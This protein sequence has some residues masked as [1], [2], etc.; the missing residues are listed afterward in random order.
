MKAI[1]QSEREMQHYLVHSA[2]SAGNIKQTT[3]RVDWEGR[4]REES[5]PS[6]QTNITKL[7]MS[8]E[9]KEALNRFE[10]QSSSLYNKEV[11]VKQLNESESQA[12]GNSLVLHYDP[13]ARPVTDAAANSFVT[14]GGNDS[15]L[16]ATPNVLNTHENAISNYVDRNSC[17]AAEEDV[18]LYHPDSGQTASLRLPSEVTNTGL[19][20]L[21]GVSTK[22]TRERAHRREAAGRLRDKEL[23]YLRQF[24]SLKEADLD[25]GFNHDA[26]FQYR[27]ELARFD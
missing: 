4:Q 8:I 16:I 24:P 23:A 10:P 7:P 2:S 14:R 27:K 9:H 20:S 13:S 17:Q 25:C 21:L 5:P 1:E 3:G 11:V 26:I 6:F 18:A 22:T 15:N 19:L 12:F